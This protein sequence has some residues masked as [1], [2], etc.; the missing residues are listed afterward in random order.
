MQKRRPTQVR[1]AQIVEAAMRIIALKGT[2]K[3]TAEL[4]GAEVGV[5]AGAVFRHFKTMDAIVEAVV[6]RMEAIL[7]EGFP[8]KAA[9]PVERVGIFF[10]RRA[11]AIVDSPHLSR[12]LLSDHLAQAGG[13]ARAARLAEFKR[14]SRSFVLACLREAQKSGRLRGT[15]GPEEGTVLILGSILALAHA[16]TSIADRGPVEQLSRRVWAVIEST[17]RGKRSRSRPPAGT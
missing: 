15:C 14:R 17:L 5:T 2:R 16:G 1:Q 9:D 3:F 4:L 7:F 11:Q 13:P 12:L 6:E 10:Q 8:P